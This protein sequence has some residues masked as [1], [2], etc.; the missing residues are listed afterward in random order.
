SKNEE[1]QKKNKKKSESNK[2]LIVGSATVLL[3]ITLI[4]GTLLKGCENSNHFSP[5]DLIEKP[6]V[7]L[8]DENEVLD[9]GEKLGTKINQESVVEAADDKTPNKEESEDI[10]ET[11]E[12][13]FENEVEEFEALIAKGD[14]EEAIKLVEPNEALDLDL[15]T[16]EMRKQGALVELVNFNQSFDT[17]YGELDELILKDDI[18]GVFNVLLALPEDLL[19]KMSND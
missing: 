14:F 5:G 2:K 7:A 17:N 16:N 11:E 15:L 18:W 10:K 12:D 4:G 1:G 8:I 6:K 3:G 19:L 13:S 9:E